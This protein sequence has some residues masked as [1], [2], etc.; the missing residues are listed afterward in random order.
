[1]LIIILLLVFHNQTSKPMTTSALYHTQ[2]T[3][4]Y[5]YK[6]TE[7][8]GRTEYYHVS[9]TASRHRCGCCGSKD[10]AIHRTNQVRR[11]HGV[12]VGL[13]KRLFALRS[14]VFDAISAAHSPESVSI[15]ALI[16]MS[17]TLNG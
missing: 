9:P 1:M 16:P 13:K 5:Q 10:T 8:K 12:P 6:K 11:I 15:F 4:G 7:R 2:G 3:V 17:A 14:D